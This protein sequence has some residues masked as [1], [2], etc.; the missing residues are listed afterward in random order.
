MKSDLNLR[1]LAHLIEVCDSGNSVSVAASRLGIAQSVVSRNI[2]SLEEHF[3]APLFIRHGRR[4][5]GP[6]PLCSALLPLLRDVKGKVGGLKEICESVLNQP[7]AGD[8]RIACTHLQARYILPQ[9]L[10]QVR[11]RHPDVKVTIH[12]CFPREINDMIIANSA[13][14][15][16]CSERLDDEAVLG[17]V[18]AYEWE[19]VLVAPRRHPLAK[20]RLTLARIA[21]EPLVT[22]VPGITGRQQFDEAFVAADMYPNVVVAAA[23]SDVI[24]QFARRGAGVGIIAEIAYER[25][26][27]RGLA[28]R[29]LPGCFKPMNAR[30]VYRQDR[31]LTPARQLFVE[32]FCQQSAALIAAA[33]RTIA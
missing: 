7:V 9:V 25:S 31:H 11:K 33:R 16:I 20:G 13:D 23:D 14:L 21:A 17:C 18:H 5:T 32:S 22:Y 29:R 2:Q 15:G 1:H 24:K 3:G 30:I 19:R 12:Q 26:A 27:D 8:I 6:T 28:A 4:L 10:D